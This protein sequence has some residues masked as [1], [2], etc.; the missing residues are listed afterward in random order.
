M[1][2]SRG[3]CFTINNDTYED[4]DEVLN[5]DD[6]YL[7]FG[8]ETG[9]EGTSHIQGYVFFKNARTMV[10]L[11]KKLTRAHL[12]SAKGTP[13]QNYDYCVKDGDYYEF[14]QLPHQGKA[15]WDKVVAAIENPRENIQ[16]YTQY[17]K[18]YYEIVNNEK[19]DHERS[20]ILASEDDRYKLAKLHDSVCF[21]PTVKTYKG[22]DVLFIDVTD[23]P[24][25]KHWYN[26]YPQSVRRGYELILV[27]PSIIYVMYSTIGWKQSA[28]KYYADYFS[29]VY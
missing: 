22:E 25:F 4:L 20:F 11:K 5:L 1:S 8:F 16:L 14:G 24:Q 13:Q 29:K 6:D 10:S 3:W 26:G 21:D 28:I 23:I 7:V 15:T 27:D 2:R 19:K 9:E 18:A 12:E 17:R